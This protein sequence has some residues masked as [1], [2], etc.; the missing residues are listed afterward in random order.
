[1]GTSVG[2]RKIDP[3]DNAPLISK[4]KLMIKEN[5]GIPMIRKLMVHGYMLDN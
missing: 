3:I 2:R 4:I 1:M 5:V